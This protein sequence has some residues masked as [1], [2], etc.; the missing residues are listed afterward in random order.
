M[1]ARTVAMLHDSCGELPLNV[2]WFVLIEWQRMS[3][4]LMHSNR[5]SNPYQKFILGRGSFVYA[6]AG[7]YRQ[8]FN[9]TRLFS[10]CEEFT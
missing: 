7:R 2:V 10:L 3:I 4:V 1:L 9:P 6:Y 5:N 8:R